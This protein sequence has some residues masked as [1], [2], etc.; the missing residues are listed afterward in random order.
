M[1]VSTRQVRLWPL[2][3]AALVGLLPVPCRAVFTETTFIAVE[4]GGRTYDL[5]VMI[6]RPAAQGRYPVALVTHGSTA[7]GKTAQEMRVDSVF[8]GWIRDFAARGYLAV[9]VMRRGY[10]L[11]DGEVFGDA[12]RCANPMPQRYIDANADDIEAVAKA[13]AKRPD[14]D[15][16]RVVG[17]GQSVGGIAMLALA[18]RNTV[19]LAAV[20]NISGGLYRYENRDGLQAYDAYDGCDRFKAAMV[21][22]MAR[23][24]AGNRVPTFWYYAENDPWFVPSF[25]GDMHA[26]WE[27]AGGLA[28]LAML[29]PSSINGHDI[30][31]EARSRRLLLPEVDTALRS[32][33]LPTWDVRQL[34][35]LSGR[36][37]PDQRP[38]FERYMRLE[39]GYKALAI[40]PSDAKTL[41]WSSRQ[42]TIGRAVEGALAGCR[43]EGHRDCRLIMRNFDPVDAASSMTSMM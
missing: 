19:K 22:A 2:L 24:G 18:A 35:V 25:V 6:A 33:S 36:F 10:G 15:V 17:V 40:S 39:P 41:F 1:P 38:L 30:F 12:G 8:A 42:P 28:K 29:K 7:A 13:L 5:E 21:E 9:G 32:L 31:Y 14:A 3:V 16:S 23:Y 4:I 26:A 43:A 20:F 11:S 37:S 34:Y 27:G